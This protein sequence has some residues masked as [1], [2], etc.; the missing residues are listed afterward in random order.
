MNNLNRYSL[1]IE[2]IVDIVALTISFLIA[3]FVKFNIPY[4]EGHDFTVDAYW[5]LY[6]VVLIGYVIIDIFILASEDIMTRS[7]RSEFINVLK[8]MICILIIMVVF[9]FFTRTS[10][11]YSRGFYLIFFIF[12]ILLDYILR[13]IVKGKFFSFYQNS[14]QA[15]KVVVVGPL[16]NVKKALTSLNSSQDWR[17]NVVGAVIADQDLKDS[18]VENVK[19]ICDYRD[20]ISVIKQEEVDD[21][22]IAT[23][24][25][26]DSINELASLFCAIGKN[27]H[28]DV[29]NNEKL[30]SYVQVTDK[31]G[32]CTVISYL[33]T[34]PVP[35]RQAVVKRVFDIALGIIL[36]PVFAVVWILSFVFT[37]IENPGPVLMNR[38]RV[39]K[40]GRRYYQFRFRLLRTDAKLRIHENKSPFTKFG[41][42]LRMTHLDGLPMILNVLSNDMSFVGPHSPTFPSFVDYEPERRKNLGIKAGIVGYWSTGLSQQE[43]VKEERNYIEHWSIKQDIY[44]LWTMMSRYITFRSTK[45]Y[46]KIRMMEELEWIEEYN[47]FKKPMAYDH[48]QY[49]YKNG[50]KDYVYLFIKRV[51]DIVMSGLAIVVL[52]PILLILI[53]LVIADDG[54]SP[55]YGHE[56]IGKYGKRIRVYKFRSMRKDAGDL[57]RLLTPEQL[58]QYKR[59]FKIDN[60]PRITKIG[61]FIRKTSLDELPQLFNI[62][63]GSLSIVGPRPIVEKETKIYGNDIAKL[64]SVKP[65]L[66]GYWQ[67]YAR[68]NATYESGERQKMEMYYVNHHSLK[69]D[70]QIIFKTFTSVLKREGA[71]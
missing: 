49:V 44:V 50:L 27:V 53:I 43:I 47:E 45:K 39:S 38:I 1:Y 63:F 54:G 12:S 23:S 35:K 60:D 30:K 2:N 15:K 56:R 51:F 8:V 62:F 69:L 48:S 33:P 4:F 5:K 11:L 52:S 70:V 37:S 34:I 32:D 65:G 67:A 68:N 24:I 55:F 19:V 26:D 31:L 14:K 46:Q 28:I 29:E 18:Y 21:V 6:F 57:E 36:L 3:K 58:E 61:N 22:F 17:F 9:A 71:Q 10:V 41:L 7:K 64:L 25:I 59:E 42:F 13:L 20:M 16:E 66:T 40:N